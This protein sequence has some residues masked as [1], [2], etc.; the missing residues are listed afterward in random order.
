MILASANPTFTQK[1]FF[2]TLTVCFWILI[3]NINLILQLVFRSHWENRSVIDSY[4]WMCLP[5]SNFLLGSSFWRNFLLVSNAWFIDVVSLFVMFHFC[6][7]PSFSIFLISAMMFYLLRGI[8]TA[9]V[10]FPM[11]QPYLFIDPEIYSFFVSYR[12][13]CDMYFSGHTGLMA[14]YMIVSKQMGWHRFRY[15]CATALV[16]TVFMLMVTGGHFMNDCILGYMA[17]RVICENSFTHKHSLVLGVI[18]CRCKVISFFG[19]NIKRARNGFKKQRKLE[20]V[21]ISN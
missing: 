3:S 18:T 15:V 14:L 17:A 6:Y 2:L 10:V 8:A 21:I 1:V 11:P 19:K 9:I 5:I 4:Q 16:L 7:D 13:L 12:I 20:T